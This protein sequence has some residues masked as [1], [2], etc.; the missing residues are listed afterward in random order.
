MYTQPPIGVLSKEVKHSRK[1]RFTYL[2]LVIHRLE[3]YQRVLVNCLGEGCFVE[4]FI[5]EDFELIG[6]AEHDIETMLFGGDSQPD[7]WIRGVIDRPARLDMNLD[8]PF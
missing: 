2:Q 5:N 4:G 3:V 7:S 8:T 1:I 6:T